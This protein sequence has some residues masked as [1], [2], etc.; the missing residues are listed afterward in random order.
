[1]GINASVTFFEARGCLVYADVDD[2]GLLTATENRWSRH[3]ERERSLF[4]GPADAAGLTELLGA[5]S[6]VDALG[7]LGAMLRGDRDA[8]A[9][10][11]ALAGRHGV[12]FVAAEYGDRDANAEG[13]GELLR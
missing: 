13:E 5:R 9:K 7:V 1:M 12:P 10:V 8:L 4:F 6:T 2:Q 3:G 11:E